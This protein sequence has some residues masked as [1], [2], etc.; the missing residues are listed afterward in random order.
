MVQF[1]TVPPTIFVQL[2]FKFVVL[3]FALHKKLFKRFL[4]F[5]GP[6]V[7]W[8]DTPHEDVLCFLDAQKTLV[9]CDGVF[10]VELDVSVLCFGTRVRDHVSA[11]ELRLT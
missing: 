6:G 11:V 8:H 5:F 1:F 7:A 2:P 10:P 3:F 9:Y 4:L